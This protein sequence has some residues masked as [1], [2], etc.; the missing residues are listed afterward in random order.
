MKFIV[1]YTP[2]EDGG[3]IAECPALPGCVTHGATVEEATENIKEA[4][5]LSLETRQELGIPG[6]EFA[7][8]IEIAV[9]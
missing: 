3:Y 1:T 6:Y 2:D 7:R 9:Q 8:E 4:I 5:L